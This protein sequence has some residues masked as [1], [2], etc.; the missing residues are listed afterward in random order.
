MKVDENTN[1]TSGN[2]YTITMN[3]YSKNTLIEQAEI[4]YYYGGE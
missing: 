3:F 1:F 4:S 2:V